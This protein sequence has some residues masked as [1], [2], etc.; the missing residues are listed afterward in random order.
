LFGTKLLYYVL[1]NTLEW[2]I[3]NK[4]DNVKPTGQESVATLLDIKKSMT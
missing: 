2:Q 3:L 4:S 1:R